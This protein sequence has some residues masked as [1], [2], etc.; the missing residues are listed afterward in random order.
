MLGDEATRFIHEFA[1]ETIVRAG[2][3]AVETFIERGHFDDKLTEQG[4][5]SNVLK[6]GRIRD[7][8]FV[9]LKEVKTEGKICYVTV[10]VHLETYEGDAEV[11]FMMRSSS[12]HEEGSS[13]TG[14]STRNPS[15]E[16]TAR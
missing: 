7:I 8:K 14:A 3:T 11:T 5:L 12:F 4:V 13:A 6:D 2:K 16:M 10:T 1:K 9:S 15:L